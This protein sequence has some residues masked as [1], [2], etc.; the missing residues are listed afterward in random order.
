MEY[1]NVCHMC[2][3]CCALLMYFLHNFRLLT[4][5]CHAL[6]CLSNLVAG[7]DIQDLGGANNVY[8]MWL[9]IGL[10][11]FKQTGI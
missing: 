7:L 8:Q 5:R 1:Y 4:L 9:N 6:L 3:K 2:I 10:L 11:I